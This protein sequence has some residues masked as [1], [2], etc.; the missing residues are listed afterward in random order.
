[1]PNPSKAHLRNSTLEERATTQK[2]AGCL[3]SGRESHDGPEALSN[4][5]PVMGIRMLMG[6]LSGTRDANDQ[7]V[8]K[9][10]RETA[11]LG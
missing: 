10:A 4:T 9:R 3:S 8:A 1:M 7:V 2:R 6:E 11:V 5:H